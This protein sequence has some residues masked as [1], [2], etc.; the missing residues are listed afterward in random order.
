MLTVVPLVCTKHLSKKSGLAMWPLGH[1]DG[2]VGRI[3][4][5]STAVLAGGVAGEGLGFA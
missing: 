4:A 3:P 5:T 1:G 2:A